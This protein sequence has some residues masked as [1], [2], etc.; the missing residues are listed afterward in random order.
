MKLALA[1]LFSALMALP[2]HGQDAGILFQAK[3]YQFPYDL[4]H[5]ETIV[6]LPSELREVS[7]IDFISS[8][9]LAA[10]QDEKGNI[11]IVGYP[12]GKIQRKIDFAGD[13]DYEDICL[14]EDD[15]WVLKSNGDLY[16]V[17]DFLYDK[18]RKVKKYETDLS[19]RNDLEGLCHDPDKERLLLA[20][21]GHPFIDEDEGKHQKGIHAFDLDKKKLSSRPVFLIDLDELKYFKKYNTMTRL[22][23]ELMANLDASKGDVTFQPSG[24]SIHPVTRNIYIIGAVGDLLLVLHPTGEMLAM[25]EL[26]DK[27]FNQPEGICFDPQGNL[28]ISNEAGEKKATLLKFPLKK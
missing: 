12:S 6:S 13:G 23:I 25:V 9:R 22:G 27:L 7:G 20:G 28:Y 11:Y 8:D 5:P 21:K 15:A 16:R 3:G 10:V 4:L 24:I 17:K 2:S 1:V 19:K 26:D 18:E 14:I